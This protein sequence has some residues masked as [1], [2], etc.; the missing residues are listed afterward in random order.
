MC[1]VYVGNTGCKNIIDQ[2]RVH[3]VED[4]GKCV[5]RRLATIFVTQTTNMQTCDAHV[6]K[7]SNAQMQEAI[8]DITCT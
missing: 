7:V 2:D 6:I 5:L 8:K 1:T 3:V 4:E